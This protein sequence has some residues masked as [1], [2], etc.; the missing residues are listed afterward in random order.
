MRTKP[1]IIRIGA[2][3]AM[4]CA[5][6]AAQ[7]RENAVCPAPDA[8]AA[9]PY[10]W[11]P[12]LDLARIPFH[13]AA[14]AW[15][16][17]AAIVAPEPPVTTRSVRVTS[18][19]QLAAE[20][21]R[22]GTLITVAAQFIGPVTIL[23]DVRDVDIV[24][25]PGHR[26]AQLTVGR[27]APPSRTERVRI[28]GTTPGAH[29]G[30]VV[31]VIRFASTLQVSDVI[32]DGLDLNGDD[33]RGGHYLWQFARGAQRVAIVNN[34]GHSATA[35]SL[36]QR[37]GSDIVIAGNL[38]LTGG[39]S[40]EEAAVPEGWGIRAGGRIVI[41]GNRIEGP[42]YHRVRLHP[43]EGVSPLYAWVADNVFVDRHE[44]RILW[45]Q[46]TPGHTA[47]YNGVWASC[48]QVYAHSTCITPSFEAAHAD[49]ARLTSNRFF[50]SI[51]EALQRG[52]QAAHG[53]GHDYLSGNTFSAWQSPPPWPAPGDPANV[54]LPAGDAG[55]RS[56]APSSMPPCPPPG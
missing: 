30:G 42:R 25:P 40:R 16:P 20:A 45:V 3:L 50:G 24:V 12:R 44:A 53:A 15:G 10:R 46:N 52:Q 5:A 54:A 29:S 37:G 51:T 43:Q 55:P 7:A 14:G 13:S 17:R 49:Y 19:A 22:P 6:A 41:Y 35:G 4:L 33:G 1:A 32:V 31:G 23:D 39:R 11:Y 27:Y 18:A 34:R 2:A 48:N 36:D 26:V 38:L 21:R 28:R 8:K 56:A 9:E 47:R